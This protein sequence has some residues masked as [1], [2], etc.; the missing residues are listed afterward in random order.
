MHRDV[1]PDNIFLD[2]DDHLV[3]GDLG[4][5]M[6]IVPPGHTFDPN[7]YNHWRLKDMAGTLQYL[8]PEMW[9]GEPYDFSID[10]WSYG[11]TVFEMI[12]GR[13]STSG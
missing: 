8:A 11:C 12:L 3:L 5:A 9:K 1:K 7:E 6:P 4:L 13:V 10:V 2:D